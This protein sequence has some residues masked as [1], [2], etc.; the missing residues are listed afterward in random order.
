MLSSSTF[1]LLCRGKLVYGILCLLGVATLLP[2]NV[3]I[4][5][6]EFFDIRVHQPPTYHAIADNFETA[7]VLIFQFVYAPGPSIEHM[8]ATV[9]FGSIL[10]TSS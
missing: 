4:T 7:I 3:F 10:M 6:N 1:C 5:E 8:S 9:V 2:W